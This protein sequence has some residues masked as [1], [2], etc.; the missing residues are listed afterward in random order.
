MYGSSVSAVRVKW[1]VSDYILQSFGGAGAVRTV[2]GLDLALCLT[3]GECIW[4][5]EYLRH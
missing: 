3:M 1:G 4:T 2:G 5:G